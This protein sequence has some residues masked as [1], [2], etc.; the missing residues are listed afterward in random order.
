MSVPREPERLDVREVASSGEVLR[1]LPNQLL[2]ELLR[3]QFGGTSEELPL[4]E[5]L[6]AL[7]VADVDAVT[8]L[9]QLDEPRV[10][11]RVLVE[12][13][14]LLE[15]RDDPP[16]AKVLL[17]SLDLPANGCELRRRETVHAFSGVL[18]DPERQIHQHSF[19]DTGYLEDD[20]LGEEGSSVRRDAVVRVVEGFQNGEV[21]DDVV[22]ALELS[23]EG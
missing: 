11:G 15:D 18:E 4:I 22:A 2:A 13:V 5:R 14:E 19:D 3:L 23:Y 1:K 9:G 21:V 8:E 16:K 7:P 17:G 20:G 10:E 6:H 12:E